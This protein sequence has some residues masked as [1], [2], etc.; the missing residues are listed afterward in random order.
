M[1][2]VMRW[3]TT[4]AVLGLILASC[5]GGDG[6]GEPAR[7]AATPVASPTAA[8]APAA[9]PSPTATQLATPTPTATPAPTPTAT[10]PTP[11]ATPTPTPSTS[12]PTPTPTATPRPTPTAAPI[13]LY[14]EIVFV[15]DVSPERQAA[16]RAEMG[17]VVAYYADRYGVEAPPFAVY[18]G[19]DAE[20]VLSVMTELGGRD[21]ETPR[22][23]GRYSR[24]GGTTD[25]IFIYGDFVNTSHTTSARVLAH[26]Y[27]HVLQKELSN[28]NTKGTPGW[29]YEGTATYEGMTYTEQYE[30]KYRNRAIIRG[31][32]YDGDLRDL[33]TEGQWEPTFGYPLGALATEFLTEQAGASSHVE[34]RRLLSV[35]ATWQEAFASAFRMTVDEFY[36]AFEEHFGRLFS[37]SPTGWMEGIVLGPAGEPLQGVGVLANGRGGTYTNW[38]T[39]TQ[40]DGT[41]GLHAPDGPNRARIYVREDD[42]W[43]QVGWYGEDGF[44]ADRSTATVIEVGATDVTGI[45]IRL[46][47]NPEDLQE[48]R[49][50]RVQGTVLGPNGEPPD[51]IRVWVWGSSTEDS[52]FSRISANGTFDID[53][54][55][56]TFTIRVYILRDG[57]IHQ[58]GWYGGEGGF[59]TDR[60]Q[61]AE[62]EVDGSDVTGIEIRL[63]ADFTD[64]P[65]IFS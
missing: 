28:Y 4:L 42:T 22:R 30:S 5:T 57:V 56:G 38:L 14:P 25:T 34:Y 21:R 62:I 50:P 15:G 9:T 39:E 6:D 10:P 44:A 23:G 16:Y 43:R 2:N 8:P 1:T 48:V 37:E 3:L 33:A 19:A 20:A 11:T 12:S 36:E 58:I 17:N 49:V 61:A 24:I 52:K 53:H 60:A 7:S 54:Q 29:L 64:L 40:S 18:I 32:N 41:F 31:A 46:P 65:T 35:T 26:E 51:G 47:A 59:T 27:F 45:E 63:P 13:P 55:N